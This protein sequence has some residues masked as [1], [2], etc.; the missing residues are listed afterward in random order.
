MDM[1]IDMSANLVQLIIDRLPS[2][3]LL[4]SPKINYFWATKNNINTINVSCLDFFS[5]SAIS[6]VLYGE[7]G[8]SSQASS[9][10]ALQYQAYWTLGISNL[11]NRTN[12]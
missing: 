2:I 11:L 12:Y 10:I 4:Y 7:C 5:D 9:G 3:S 6:L 8:V 1:P